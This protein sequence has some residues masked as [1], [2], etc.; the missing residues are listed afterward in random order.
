MN[1]RT[2]V[3]LCHVKPKLR[4]TVQH[5]LKC[6]FFSILKMD[7]QN[8]DRK[9][10]KAA[11]FKQVL[12]PA[13]FALLHRMGIYD[14]IDHFLARSALDHIAFIPGRASASEAADRFNGLLFIG[15]SS[16]KYFITEALNI[17]FPKLSVPDTINAISIMTDS[18][19]LDAIIM[20]FSLHRA[21]VCLDP[22]SASGEPDDAF[23]ADASR[24]SL[25][26]LLGALIVST[27]SFNSILP[28]LRFNFLAAIDGT[29]S[30]SVIPS[31]NEASAPAS[32]PTIIK[33]RLYPL[34]D[35][36]YSLFILARRLGYDK[37]VYRL[38]GETGRQSN[39]PL[40]IVGVYCGPVKLG[41]AFGSSITLAETRAARDALE[42]YYLE[43]EKNI[44]I[45]PS[46]AGTCNG[47]HS[48]F[49]PFNLY[50]AFA[51]ATHPPNAKIN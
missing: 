13:Q 42:R 18:P 16:V 17:T 24:K 41:E 19:I 8:G 47:A 6:K 2:L 23:V 38:E 32:T 21:I 1:C 43:E 36:R 12:E 27:K 50:D 45:L 29:S 25:L 33:S 48:L 9:I 39:E 37:P 7:D 44:S 26:A 10:Q 14:S 20:K 3:S 5:K 28:F 31:P 51:A 30:Y 15:A 34:R 22:S 46:E 11:E 4:L 40:Y 49:K 35:F